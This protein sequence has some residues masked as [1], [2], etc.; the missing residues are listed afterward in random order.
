M[1]VPSLDIVEIFE[2]QEKNELNGLLRAKCFIKSLGLERFVSG[3]E[4]IDCKIE[5]IDSTVF[6]FEQINKTIDE[7]LRKNL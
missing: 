1:L 6:K 4:D 7:F 2:R 3:I 5:L